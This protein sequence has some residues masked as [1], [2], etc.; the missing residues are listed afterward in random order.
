STLSAARGR[1]GSPARTPEM[2]WSHAVTRTDR[3]MEATRN[4]VNSSQATPWRRHRRALVAALAAICVF[5]TTAS[6]QAGTWHAGGA[7]APASWSQI[8]IDSSNIGADSTATAI[9]SLAL[10]TAA[11]PASGATGYVSA[12]KRIYPA[13]DDGVSTAT[14]G[15]AVN[16]QAA[17]TTPPTTT[18][19]PAN[20]GIDALAI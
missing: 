4:D 9:S 17:P 2:P 18:E 11:S 15:A 20:G 13:T 16:T 19:V 12:G 5:A 8:T 7:G 3:G 14:I 6:A 1:P 10:S